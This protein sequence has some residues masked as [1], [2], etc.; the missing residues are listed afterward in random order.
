MRRNKLLWRLIFLGVIAASVGAYYAC[1]RLGSRTG[2]QE[3]ANR[4]VRVEVRAGRVYYYLEDPSGK[5]I[6]VSMG[7]VELPEGG[8][9][10]LGIHWPNPN[11]PG[12]GNSDK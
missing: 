9:E 10:A 4:V 2:G 7:P 6:I 1:S 12:G 8:L 3:K 11:A 5:P